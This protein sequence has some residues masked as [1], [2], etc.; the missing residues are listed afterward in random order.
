MG[1]NND[2]ESL[3]ESV[4]RENIFL[5]EQ[6]ANHDSENSV[7]WNETLYQ[8]YEEYLLNNDELR[9]P[10]FIA[11]GKWQ[12]I[13]NSYCEL[14][15]ESFFGQLGS[16][17]EVGTRGDIF[18]EGEPITGVLE[19]DKVEKDKIRMRIAV[20][21]EMGIVEYIYCDSGDLQYFSC[22]GLEERGQ[23]LPE[24]VMCYGVF[25]QSQTSDERPEIKEAWKGWKDLYCQRI[26][27]NLR[28]YCIIENRIYTIDRE[29]KA[30]MDVTYESTGYVGKWIMQEA[31][32]IRC[33]MMA[34]SE[35]FEC[36]EEM[37]PKGYFADKRCFCVCDLNG[38]GF[39]DYVIAAYQSEHEEP[40][41][42]RYSD[43]IWLYLSDVDGEYDRKV[44]LDGISFQCF[45]LKFVDGGML[46]CEDTFAYEG[47]FIDPWRTDYFYYD[48]EKEE[49]CLYKAYQGNDGEILIYGE[50]TL[51]EIT[52]QEYYQYYSD[53]IEGGKQDDK[54]NLDIH[55]EYVDAKVI[56]G[57]VDSLGYEI[58][59]I[60]DSD[61]YSVLN[62]MEMIPKEEMVE[63]CRKGMKD[64]YRNKLDQEELE[65]YIRYIEDGYNRNKYI[66]FLGFLGQSIGETGVYYT[67]TPWG[68]RIT[69]K[70]RQEESE[71]VEIIS[72]M[73]DKEFFINTA[74]WYY[75]E[76]GL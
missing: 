60:I 4:E 73:V 7:Q 71:K 26:E 36:V 63:I 17:G 46:M 38:D 66:S 75:M 41:Y 22:R 3:S 49:F 50:E 8:K 10:Y 74:L 72:V 51:G 28:E 54:I 14:W 5:S 34:T 52:I 55:M 67:I 6:E 31:E 16:K 59:V 21:D 25:D 30:L 45:T 42:N 19:A 68:V 65:K 76:P 11:G 53:E 39:E 69:F 70:E 57:S 61:D 33:G 32:R 29:N 18:M 37:L 13:E 20:G 47:Y 1:C 64:R 15:G 35:A 58:P 44:L 40:L 9:E 27:G 2:R 43:E 12:D 24:Y 48:E 62:I 23:D 56:C